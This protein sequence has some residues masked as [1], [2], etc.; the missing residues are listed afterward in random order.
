[1]TNTIAKRQNGNA[2]RGAFGNVVDN[3]FQNS[4]RRFFDDNFWEAENQQAT[5]SIP[6]NIRETEQQYELDV[7][8]P[9]C[10]KEDFK[11]NVEDNLL[12]IS[13][14]QV[15]E[16]KQQ[17]GKT[18]WERNEYVQRSFSRSFSLD[19]TVD[20]NNINAKYTDGILRL[21]LGKNEKAKKLSKSIEVK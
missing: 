9:G 6:V 2:Y 18:G 17:D 15:N 3:L 16:K 11:I 1:M 10:K 14:N 4:L 5:G 21:S 12:T 7:I 20:L 19:D 13:M 8:A